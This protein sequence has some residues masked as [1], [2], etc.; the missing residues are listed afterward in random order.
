M[1]VIQTGTQNNA[2]MIQVSG[3][4]DAVTAPEFEKTLN[5]WIDGGNDR[6]VADLGNLEYI[7]SAGLRSILV[8]AKKLKAKNGKI[9]LAAM[10][11]SVHEVFE[12]S[13]FN[14][15]IPIADTVETAIGQ[16]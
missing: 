12:I 9:I 13:G 1:E 3:R 6:I 4:M 2:L 10:E 8:I 14:A 7:S 5:Q 15:I 11:E 16:I